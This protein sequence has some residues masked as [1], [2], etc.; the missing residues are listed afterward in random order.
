MA[1]RGP[2]DPLALDDSLASQAECAESK[3]DTTRKKRVKQEKQKR[4]TR[5]RST[6]RAP[7]QMQEEI[8]F[9]ALS[10]APT[11]PCL[12]ELR[13]LLSL[14][15]LGESPGVDTSNSH[16]AP[17]VSLATNISVYRALHAN[18][19][20]PWG[21][22]SPVKP[23]L[24]DESKSKPMHGPFSIMEFDGDDPW[25]IDGEDEE[26]APG[27]PDPALGDVGERH[28]TYTTASCESSK[29]VGWIP[30]V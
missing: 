13:Q 22:N 1:K 24:L 16:A 29:V 25:L 14:D 7:L 10:A 5:N 6:K 21:P 19:D 11:S 26:A 23:G 8:G 28:A 17:G 30:N 15:E 4:Q 3:S 27:P 2:V 9:I 20:G 18:F 12:K